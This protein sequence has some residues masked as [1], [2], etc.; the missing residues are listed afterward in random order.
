MNTS[1]VKKF[2]MTFAMTA[3]S[4][5]IIKSVPQLDNLIFDDGWF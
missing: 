4:I 2:A 5:K 3:V 1:Q